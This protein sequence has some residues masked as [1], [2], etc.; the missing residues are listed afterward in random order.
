VG[1]TVALRLE[2]EDTSAHSLDIDEFT[3]QTLL[4]AG[5]TSLA[6]FTP[7]TAGSYTFYCSLPGHREAGMVGTLVVEP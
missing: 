4:P 6:L 3:I 7:S 1:E 5:T 2:N